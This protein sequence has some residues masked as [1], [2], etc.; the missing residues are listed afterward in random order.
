MMQIGQSF[1]LSFAQLHMQ[2]DHQTLSKYS[3]E[4]DTLFEQIVGTVNA[5]SEVA[6]LRTSMSHITRKPGESIQTPLYRLKTLYE[7]LIQINFPDLDIEKIKV[8]ADNYAC[9]CAKFLIT[10]NTAKILTEYIGIKQQRD[11]HLNLMKL[12]NVITSHEAGTPGDRIQ[13]ILNLPTSATRL[14]ASI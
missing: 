6:K 13:Q 2:N 7:M 11:E 4:V 10:P 14:D 5:D 12:C 1:F 3:D 9:N 8:R